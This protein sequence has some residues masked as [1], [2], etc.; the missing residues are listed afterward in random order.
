[1]HSKSA[2]KLSHADCEDSSGEQA[3]SSIGLAHH[4][5]AD[6]K[7]CSHTVV[8][9]EVALHSADESWHVRN[10]AVLFVLRPLAGVQV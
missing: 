9:Y 1:M 2:D 4:G 10:R 7:V 3:L 8:I 5:H 6:V